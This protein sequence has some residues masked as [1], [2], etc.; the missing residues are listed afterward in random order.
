MFVGLYSHLN[1]DDIVLPTIHCYGFSAEED[2]K[3]DIV[4]QIE[5]ILNSSIQPI[6][7][8]EV[9]DVAPKKLMLCVSFKL[10]MA[11]AV[12]NDGISK[13]TMDEKSETEPNGKKNKS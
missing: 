3:A 8:H 6:R 1:K 2:P 12:K 9:R 10:P 11:V 7:V 4:L 5:K 13:R